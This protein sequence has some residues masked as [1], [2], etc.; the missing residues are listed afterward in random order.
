MSTPRS[1]SRK[2]TTKGGNARRIQNKARKRTIK[3]KSNTKSS[4]PKTASVRANKSRD[5]IR[6]LK[7][8]SAMSLT[9]LQF[10]AKTKGVPFGGLTRTRLKRKLDRYII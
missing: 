8:N 10:I 9:E 6:I 7:P 1:K 5:K 3:R 4:I 2:S